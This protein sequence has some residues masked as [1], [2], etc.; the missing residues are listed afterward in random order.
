MAGGQGLTATLIGT[1]RD[2]QGGVLP[3][4]NVSISSHERAG[5]PNTQPTNEKGQLRFQALLPG[6][7]TIEVRG[8]PS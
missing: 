8:T 5:E 7:Y 2:E 1:V 4:A 3:G 6:L